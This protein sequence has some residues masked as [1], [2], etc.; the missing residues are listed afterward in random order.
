MALTPEEIAKRERFDQT[1]RRSPCPAI[2]AVEAGLLRRG[3][4]VAMPRLA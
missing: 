2:L 4:F 3:L 1:Y